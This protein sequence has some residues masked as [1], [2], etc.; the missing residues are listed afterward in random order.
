[1]LKINY[2]PNPNKDLIKASCTT[3][4]K[5]HYFQTGI[6]FRNGTQTSFNTKKNTYIYIYTSIYILF[7]HNN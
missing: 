1:M 6:Y 5:I 7:F 4:E 3:V 2:G